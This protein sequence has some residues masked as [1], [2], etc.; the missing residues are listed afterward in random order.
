MKPPVL[1]SA[2][3]PGKSGTPHPVAIAEKCRARFKRPLGDAF[4]LTQFGVNRT[5]LAPGVW[6][7]VRH[8]HT[9]ED[10]FVVVLEG[11]LIL[12]TDGGESA[13]REGDCIGFKAGIADGHRLENRSEKDAVYLEIGSRRQDDITHYSDE[14]L[15]AAYAD[16]WSPVFTRRDGSPIK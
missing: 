5:T 12:V 13:M 4:G 10:E 7:T 9:A 16:D 1:N 15:L 6:S 2:D 3:A 11:E 8:W 14:D